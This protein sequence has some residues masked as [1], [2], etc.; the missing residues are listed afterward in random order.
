MG[1][2]YVGLFYCGEDEYLKWEMFMLDC[3]TELW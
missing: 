2:V 3:F 1:N